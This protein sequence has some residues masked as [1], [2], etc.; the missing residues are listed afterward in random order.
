MVEWNSEETVVNGL[1]VSGVHTA[2]VDDFNLMVRKGGKDDLWQPSVSFVEPSESSFKKLIFILDTTCFCKFSKVEDAKDAAIQ[3][4][5]G[6]VG[7]V[8]DKLRG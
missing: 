4:L 6:Y 5:L 1:V 2:A 8:A 3:G 7:S